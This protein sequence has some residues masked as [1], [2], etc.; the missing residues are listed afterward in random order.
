MTQPELPIDTETPVDPDAVEARCAARV[1]RRRHTASCEGIHKALKDIELYLP[2]L[3]CNDRRK[4]AML[5][6]VGAIG[7]AVRTSLL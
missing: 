4:A 1:A 3:Q 6:Y 7:Y 5:V 2:D